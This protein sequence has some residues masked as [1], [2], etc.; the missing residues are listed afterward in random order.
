MDSNHDGA[1]QRGGVIVCLIA[2]N[3]HVTQDLFFFASGFA[4]FFGHGIFFFLFIWP[5][6]AGEYFSDCPTYE[7]HCAEEHYAS[8]EDL[9]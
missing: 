5:A 9:N 8:D 6:E 3:K 4:A 1:I 7:A 2:E